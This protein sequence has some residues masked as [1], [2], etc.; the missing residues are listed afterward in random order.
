MLEGD[1]GVG[2]TTL[3][4]RHQTGEFKGGNL[5]FNRVNIYNIIF[6]TSLGAIRFNILDILSSEKYGGLHEGY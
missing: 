1:G 3:L 5:S 2:K 4:N 6:H